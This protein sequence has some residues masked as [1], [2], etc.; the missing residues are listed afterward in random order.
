MG[1][2]RPTHTGSIVWGS[3]SI[4]FFFFYNFV[5][6]FQYFSGTVDC[7]FDDRIDV[8]FRFMWLGEQC[9]CNGLIQPFKSVHN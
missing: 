3:S 9:D 8:S 5:G 7:C 2:T 1:N 6:V 4:F